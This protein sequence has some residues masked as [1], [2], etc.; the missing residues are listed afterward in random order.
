MYLDKKRWWLLVLTAIFSG[1]AFNSYQPGRIFFL[2]PLIF[3]V[4][5]KIKLKRIVGLYLIPFIIVILPMSIILLSNPQNDIRFNQ[6]F[7]LKNSS[8]SL[9]KKISF[10]TENVKSTTLMF[11]TK[12][13]MNGQHN[14]TGK[15]ALNPVMTSFLII[16]LLVAIAGF[17]NTS[18]L[19]FL[20]YFF[21]GAIPTIL[22]YP[23]ENP[24]ML[25]TYTMLPSIVYFIGLA[26]MFLYAFI[27]KKFRKL[28]VMYFIL[29]TVLLAISVLYE[30]RTYF[31]YQPL[32]F[33]QAFDV[34]D[35]LPIIRKNS[36]RNDL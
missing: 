25:R 30:L 3:L 34:P 12:G 29:V 32:V 14:Y 36:H 2:L 33:R 26:V 35:Y 28:I 6:Q 23:W 27:R 20:I 18:H 4:I 31:V 10:L 9:G 16:G 15:P 17:R 24:N 22:T 21:I 7:F 13:D 5:K 11:F 1:I 19:F 8:L